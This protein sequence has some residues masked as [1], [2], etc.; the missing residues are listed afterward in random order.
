MTKDLQIPRTILNK[1]NN[2][3]KTFKLS[4]SWIKAS[5]W[6]K[7]SSI[8]KPSSI[9]IDFCTQEFE[10]IKCHYTMYIECIPLL[11]HQ[12]HTYN[13]D[14][15]LKKLLTELKLTYYLFLLFPAFLTVHTVNTKEKVKGIEILQQR[16]IELYTWA[17]KI[18]V[19]DYTNATKPING[20]ALF[21][22]TKKFSSSLLLT[23]IIL[24][25]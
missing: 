15:T 23:I 18:L 9:I 12:A 6:C 24:Q 11:V 1:F 4:V 22:W 13:V 5:K 21:F 25:T 8:H 19:T 14:A 16:S 10:P 3:K 2:R 7:N 17:K 20:C